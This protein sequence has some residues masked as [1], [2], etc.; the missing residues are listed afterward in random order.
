MFKTVLTTLT[1]AALTFNVVTTTASAEV[2]L[3]A[4][5]TTQAENRLVIKQL[6]DAKKA[7]VAFK[8]MLHIKQISKPYVYVRP[9]RNQNK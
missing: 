5:K 6:V 2:D 7:R 1:V 8:E 4:I 3:A 9:I